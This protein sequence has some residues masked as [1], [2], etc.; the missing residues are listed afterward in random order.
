MTPPAI[1]S[2]FLQALPSPA[3]PAT[4]GATSDLYSALIGDWDA[5]V[6]DH[7]PDSADRRQSAEM[8][9]AWVLE[10]RAVQDLWI[11]PA[12]RERPPS[13][14]VVDGNRYGTTLRVY[15]P[16]LDVWR[17]TWW[18]PVTGAENRL[19]GR[20]VGS[21]IV[22]T[23]AD[24]DGRLIRWVFDVVRADQFHWRG[25]RSEDG[26][27]TWTCDTEFFA[28]RAA[29]Q[30]VVERR[31]AWGWTDRPGI[32]T[33]RFVRDPAGARAE[34]SALVVFDGQPESLRYQVE[35]DAAWRLRSARAEIGA[36]GATRVLTLRRD[37]SGS[38]TVDG[39]ARPDLADCED[40]DLMATPYT[41]T[42]PL[43]A[44]P[45]APGDSRRLRVAWVRF[46]DLAVRT[47]TQEYTRL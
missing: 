29:A 30:P 46:P 9:F 23:G 34:G 35:H 16:K 6:V 41:N 5:E 19:V 13:T 10:G 42:P 40:V 3:P 15:D 45:L 14:A 31:V 27:K 25:E 44:H 18:N 4:R 8:H 12:R 20:R 36:P 7:L 33:L 17:V 43:A 2:A 11:V 47:V 26:G 37:E 39:V 32:E 22:Q 1:D 24:A 28:R 38:W 21:Q